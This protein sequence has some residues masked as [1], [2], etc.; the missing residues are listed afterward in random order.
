MFAACNRRSACA[1]VFFVAALPSHQTT[2][3][4]FRHH[5]SEIAVSGACKYLRLVDRQQQRLL[6]PVEL[7]HDFAHRGRAVPLRRGQFS[8][9]RAVDPRKARA[10]LEPLDRLAEPRQ[11]SL[12]PLRLERVIQRGQQR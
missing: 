3:R 12:A 2:L 1:T 7:L 6:L 10:C 11:H 5:V 8:L 4:G 9:N